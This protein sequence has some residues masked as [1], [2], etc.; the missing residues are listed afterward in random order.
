MM[1]QYEVGT[2]L[3]I[4]H[5]DRPGLVAYR[6]VEEITKKTL[7]GEK[8]QYLAQPAVPNRKPVKLESVKG[9]IF[10]SGEEA[11]FALIENATRAIDGMID[12]TQKLINQVFQ[13]K[14][15][16]PPSI[17]QMA[18][19]LDRKTPEKLKNGYQWVEMEDGK[20]VQVKIP[21]NLL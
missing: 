15:T 17:V 4:I 3:W 11:K 1:S 6:V 20:K 18:P 5:T 7:E 16:T 12:K 14:E 13:V 21:E 9:R 8:I 19:P 10:H 2:I